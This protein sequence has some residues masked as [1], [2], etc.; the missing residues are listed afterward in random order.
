MKNSNPPQ[1]F[2]LNKG[3]SSQETY[4]DYHSMNESSSSNWGYECTYQLLPDGLNGEH[5]ILQL[6]TMQLSFAS[7]PGG[8]MHDTHTAKGT[9][10]IAVIKEVKDRACFDRMKLKIGDILFFDDSKPFNLMSNDTFIFSVVSIRKNSLGESLPLFTKALNHRIKDKD[11]R[12][13]TLLR[14]TWEKFTPKDDSLDY[15]TTEKVIIKQIKNLLES[16]TLIPSTLSKGEEIA[17]AIRNQ[18]YHHMDGKISVSELSKQYQV[19][20]KTLQNSFKSLFG[21]TPKRF[22][23]QLKLNHVR[24]ELKNSNA[25]Q[26]TVS[27]SAHRWGFTHMGSFSQY[28]T[29]L[30]NEN[31]SQTLKDNSLKLKSINVSCAQR[32]EEI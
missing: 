22:L 28:Y 17:L 25:S 32:K 9:V 5:K 16:Q 13:E 6:D 11:K 18:V 4:D 8:M 1:E 7:R 30:F 23:R 27:K 24:N 12:L 21:F 26:T 14:N 10:V 19:S 2:S 20:E 29:E 15:K 31:P 3:F